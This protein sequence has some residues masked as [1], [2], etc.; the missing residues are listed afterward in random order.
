MGYVLM[1]F[2]EMFLVQKRNNLEAQLQRVMQ[3]KHDLHK[4]SSAI[5]SDGILSVKEMASMP[6]SCFG[7][8][9]RYALYGHGNI[10]DKAWN[11]GIYI[12]RSNQGGVF[13][14]NE[15]GRALTDP[16]YTRAFE[17]A[18]A[19][20]EIDMNNPA[21]QQTANAIYYANAIKEQMAKEEAKAEKE[22]IKVLE[23]DL[24]MEQKQLETQLSVTRQEEQQLG[25]AKKQDIQSSVVKYA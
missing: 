14:E 19:R 2:R 15:F 9:Q 16:N 20:G 18:Q 10:L 17:E 11:R 13:N 7:L 4:Y 24:D 25:E 6:I 8:A 23:D 22:R 5:A 1:S 12:N 21:M 3:Q